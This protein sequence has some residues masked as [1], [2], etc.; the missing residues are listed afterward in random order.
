VKIIKEFRFG[1]LI[2]RI[3]YRD[4]IDTKYEEYIHSKIEFKSRDRGV[5]GIVTSLDF[6]LKLTA[7]LLE[8]DKDSPSLC[9]NDF[10][11][12]K[13]LANITCAH[14]LTDLYGNEIKFNLSI[15]ELFRI[16]KEEWKRIVEKIG[17]GLII[18]EEPVVIY[19][20][21]DTV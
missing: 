12:L 6:S 11:A 8:I 21:L 13:E 16:T 4:E 2:E 19:V 17:F 14:F 1:S 9:E 5:L 15:P 18:D 20:N 10:D 3:V 7:E